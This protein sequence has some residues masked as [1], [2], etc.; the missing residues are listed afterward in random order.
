MRRTWRA[1]TLIESL[2]TVAVIGVLVSLVMV[3]VASARSRA[4]A[5]ASLSNL[6]TH[7]Q[8]MSAYAG[9]WKDC[10]PLFTEPVSAID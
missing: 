6:R 4:R 5:A 3:G 1:F 8:V 10:W 9:D 7:A 2:V